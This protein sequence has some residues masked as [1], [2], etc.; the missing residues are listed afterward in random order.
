MPYDY[1]EILKKQRENSQYI[2][3]EELVRKNLWGETINFKQSRDWISME[4]KILIRLYNLLR[5]S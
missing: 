4:N 2:E 1:Y 3:T 5:Y